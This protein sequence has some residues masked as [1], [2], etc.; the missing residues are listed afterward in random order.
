MFLANFALSSRAPCGKKLTA[1]DA[2]ILAKGAGGETPIHAVVEYTIEL[3]LTAFINY[4][5]FIGG[6]LP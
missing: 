6:M 4:P 5:A 3:A 1:K 2:K